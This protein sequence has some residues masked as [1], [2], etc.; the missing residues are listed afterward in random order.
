MKD[1]GF[2]FIERGEATLKGFD[3]PIRLYE[4]PWAAAA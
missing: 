3:E 2:T 4:V 1:K